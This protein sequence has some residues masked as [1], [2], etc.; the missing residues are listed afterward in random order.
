MSL[1]EQTLTPTRVA[2]LDSRLR[3]IELETSA[4]Q[5]LITQLE[6]DFDTL[7]HDDPARNTLQKRLD[8]CYQKESNTHQT[9]NLLLT[10]KNIYLSAICSSPSPYQINPTL[11]TPPLSP[12]PSSYRLSTHASLT[13]NL[14]SIPNITI[15]AEPNA[16]SSTSW[17]IFMSYAWANSQEALEKSHIEVADACGPCDPRAVARSLTQHGYS[18]WLDAD[19]LADGEALY[20]N[21]V[22]AILP[23]HCMVAC[24]S[25]AYVASINC[26][27]E[28]HFASQLHIPIVL[29]IVGK[30]SYVDW[31]KSMVGFLAGDALYID[32][33]QSDQFERILEAVSRKVGPP[34]DAAPSTPSAEA[35]SPFEKLLAQGEAGDVDAQFKLGLVH[36]PWSKLGQAAR[37]ELNVPSLESISASQISDTASILDDAASIISED[38]PSSVRPETSSTFT[39]NPLIAQKWYALAADQGHRVAQYNLGRLYEN[40]TGLPSGPDINLAIHYYTMSSDQNDNIAQY[41]LGCIYEQGRLVDQNLEEAAKWFTASAEKGHA[42]AQFKL[43]RMYEKGVDAV[44][45]RDMEEAGRLFRLS[46]QKGFVKS[47]C[48]VRKLERRSQY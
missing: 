25:E 23:A 34:T 36:D 46:A 9:Y 2:D 18:T 47:Q 8:R 13:P 35:R 28:F 27:R 32:S 1:R 4:L 42:G 48:K 33:T 37:T 14:R 44:G 17:Q 30:E 3:D 38:I 22:D 12:Y 29:V 5:D 7:E 24:I 19:R 6:N 16:P 45:G 31:R 11:P 40:G 26:Q 20:N 21:L 39:V 41:R 43:G 15:N 10:Q